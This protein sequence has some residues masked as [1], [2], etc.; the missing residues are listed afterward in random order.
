MV[1][2]N[3]SKKMICNQTKN[4]HDEDQNFNYVERRR[5]CLSCGYR[6][7]TVEIPQEL[8]TR[9]ESNESSE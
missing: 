2:I 1:C 8:F 9:N 6:L 3:C 7:K 5:V 4:Y